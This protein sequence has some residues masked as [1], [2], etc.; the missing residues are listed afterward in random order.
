MQTSQN[1]QVSASSSVHEGQCLA[2]LSGTTEWALIVVDLSSRCRH[3]AKG[4]AYA[5]KLKDTS[6]RGKEKKTATLKHFQNDFLQT[7]IS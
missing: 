5:A 2:I 4:A 1:P 3:A 7:Q 6:S